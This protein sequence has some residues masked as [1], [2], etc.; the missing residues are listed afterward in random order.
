MFAVEIV[1]FEVTFVV[2][3]TRIVFSKGIIIPFAVEILP[4]EGTCVFRDT[5]SVFSMGRTLPVL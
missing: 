5:R 2:K 3:D 4:C 1:P